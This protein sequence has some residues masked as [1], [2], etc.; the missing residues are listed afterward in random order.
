MR[1]GKALIEGDDYQK[2]LLDL[3]STVDDKSSDLIREAER[4]E[5]AGNRQAMTRILQGALN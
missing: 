2:S 3:I 1:I 4:S 5:T